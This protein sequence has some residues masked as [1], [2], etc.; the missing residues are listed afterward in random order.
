MALAKSDGNKKMGVGCMVLFAL[1]FFAV[2]AG[3]TGWCAWIALQH[4]AMQS[5]V[6]TP[7]VIKDVQLK[8]IHGKSTSYQV[9]ADY[10]YQ[11]GGRSYIGERVSIGGDSDNFYQYQQEIYQELK[12][13]L[14]RKQPFRCFV[15]PDRPSEAVLYRDLRGEMM[16]F[17]TLFATVFGSAGLGLATGVI[18][19]ARWSP[20]VKD[21][22]PTDA[23]WTSRADWKAGL[24]PAGNNT[25]V[26]ATTMTVVAVYALIAMS[27]LLWKFPE[28]FAHSDKFLKWASF[29]FPLVA[30]LLIA[31]IIYLKIR[32]RKFGQSTLLL[33]STP[34]VIGGQLAGVVRVP[35]SIAPADGF[36]LT[37]NCLDW[38]SSGK[39]RSEKSVWQDEQVVMEPMSGGSKGT[40]I[41]VLFAIPFDCPETTRP[42]QTGE[43]HWRL[44]VAARV[45]GVDYQAK[46]D[47]PVFKTAES[48]P[49]FKLDEGLVAQ[50]GPGPNP[51]LV[52]RE[53]GIIKEPL[54]GGVRLEFPMARHAAVA[55][56]FTAAL[57]G[58]LIVT[59]AM[60]AAAP[61]MAIIFGL[62]SLLVVYMV[63]GLWFYRS[64]AEALSSGLILRGGLM[65]IGR[66]R[67]IPV[68]DIEKF[69]LDEGMRSGTTVWNNIVVVLRNGKKH[70]VGK[71]ISGKLAQRIVIDELQT[72]LGMHPDDNVSSPK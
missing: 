45:P 51:D 8:V 59:W 44:D 63:L 29:A 39:S 53:A 57:A 46:F 25:K 31:W 37:L 23:P 36:R 7:T 72:A 58:M 69:T 50:V 1:P 66:T 19:A 54:A 13:H 30:L 11:F 5:W 34:G 33:A 64:V 35:K 47:V 14:D 43:I 21:D 16:S 60:H 52:L 12:Q 3:T 10:K 4:S 15:N 24:I 28:V 65:G 42:G 49:D 41:P 2:G 56:V 17:Y 32:E 62:F 68:E 18:L 61:I 27:P 48:R 6:E 20:T 55:L 71:L 67:V 22:V 26:A 70:T 9:V 40:A 38:V